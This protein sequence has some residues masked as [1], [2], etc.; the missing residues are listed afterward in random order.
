M[1]FRA[2][3]DAV[4]EKRDGGEEADDKETSGLVGGNR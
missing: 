1:L 2:A 3:R 4:T